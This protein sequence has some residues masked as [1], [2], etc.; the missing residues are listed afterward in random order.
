M[1]IYL[2]IHNH[3]EGLTTDAV[4]GAHA[5]DLEVQEK[6]GVAPHS[7]VGMLPSIKIRGFPTIPTT[8]AQ[9]GLHKTRMESVTSFLR[10]P[11]ATADDSFR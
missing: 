6:H 9:G 5:R 8:Q 1:P 2:D 11:V 3:G 10:L 7:I 4:K